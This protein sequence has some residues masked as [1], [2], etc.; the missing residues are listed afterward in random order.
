MTKWYNA[1][2]KNTGIRYNDTPIS[3]AAAR[4]EKE[5][6]DYCPS[7]H[8]NTVVK[9]E[10]NDYC[11]HC[12][13]VFNVKRDKEVETGQIVESDNMDDNEETLVSTMTPDP[14][15]EFLNRGKVEPQGGLKALQDRGL[16]IT[17]YTETDGAGRV[18]KKSRW[19]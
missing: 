6:S 5:D 16:K 17:S 1:N 12:K 3:I 10:S 9:E 14:N 2:H 15:E 13:H 19:T 18:L 4:E 11:T 8:C 7:C